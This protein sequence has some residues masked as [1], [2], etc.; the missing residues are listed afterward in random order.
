[1]LTERALIQSYCNII[2]WG[3]ALDSIRGPASFVIAN[4][5]PGPSAISFPPS[6]AS[7]HRWASSTITNEQ[8]PCFPISLS[9]PWSGRNGF[10]VV[11][12]SRRSWECSLSRWQMMRKDTAHFL[13]SSPSVILQDHNLQREKNFPFMKQ[14]KS[15]DS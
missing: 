11:S 7:H 8:V 6:P 1:M 3:R 2:Y 13:L 14:N 5:Y 12:G 10:R 15:L 9:E 4:V